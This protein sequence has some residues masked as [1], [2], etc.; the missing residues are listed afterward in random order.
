MLEQELGYVIE[1]PDDQGSDPD[2]EVDE[3]VISEKAGIDEF[4]SPPRDEIHPSELKGGG[5]RVDF[6]EANSQRLD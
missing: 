1:E 4:D 6:R 3:K 5:Y 2:V